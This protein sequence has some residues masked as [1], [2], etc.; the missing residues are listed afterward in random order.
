MTPDVAV[1]KLLGYSPSLTVK[2]VCFAVE[3]ET[4]WPS[5][6]KRTHTDE[7]TS[8]PVEYPG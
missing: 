5:E 3:H 6:P 8:V 4:T 1:R 7:S 2:H